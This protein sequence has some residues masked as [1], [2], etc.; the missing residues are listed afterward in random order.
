MP[1]SWTICHRWRYRVLHRNAARALQCRGD[2]YLRTKICELAAATQAVT[3]AMSLAPHGKLNT[4]LRTASDPAWVMGPWKQRVAQLQI[5][6]GVTCVCGLPFRNGFLWCS[7]IC[8]LVTQL[9]CVP[10]SMKRVLEAIRQPLGHVR[11]SILSNGCTLMW[12]FPVAWVSTNALD[13]HQPNR[14]TCS[15][16]CLEIHVAV[17][18]EWARR[19]LAMTAMFLWMCCMRFEYMQRSILLHLSTEHLV[20][21]CCWGKNKPGYPWC[22][23]AVTW[24]TPYG[25]TGG[26]LVRRR[27]R[28]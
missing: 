27:I 8:V 7:E 18:E 1:S 10:L 6:S 28:S 12:T 15:S 21:N 3:L 16:R 2:S 20:G 24:V 13:Q 22:Q 19:D 14:E 11:G 9:L 25:V 17:E 23:Q 4:E 5:R 26:R